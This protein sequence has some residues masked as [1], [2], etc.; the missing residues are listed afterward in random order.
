MAQFKVILSHF[1][2]KFEDAKIFHRDFKSTVES[3]TNGEVE[4]ESWGYSLDLKTNSTKTLHY[5]DD[6]IDADLI[7]DRSGTIH[8]FPGHLLRT[9]ALQGVQVINHPVAFDECKSL[10]YQIAQ[11]IGIPVPK[12]TVVLPGRFTKFVVAEDTRSKSGNKH[13]HEVDFEGIVEKLGGYPVYLKPAHGGGKVDVE[14]CDCWNDLVNNYLLLKDKQM[15]IQK[16]VDFDHFVRAFALGDKIMIIKYLPDAPA[17][18]RYVNDPHHLS[19][20]EG[21]LLE[22]YIRKMNSHLGYVINTLEFAREKKTG[23]WYAI[24]FTNGCNFDMRPCELGDSIY[25]QALHA[26]ADLAIDYVYNPRMIRIM[27]QN[28]PMANRRLLE[29]VKNKPVNL[30][31]FKSDYQTYKETFN[32]VDEV[33]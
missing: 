10:D 8:S 27:P 4:V 1:I 9:A 7:L 6:K 22:S 14:K 17:S 24:D 5:L 30:D 33:L 3:K 13:K 16:G 28:T 29:R 19:Q 12:T 23:N 15:I 31:R 26:L 18:Q 11:E 20:K 25:T 21:M 2:P 32:I